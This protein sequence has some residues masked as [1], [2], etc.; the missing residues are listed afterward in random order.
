MTVRRSPN[1]LLAVFGI[2]LVVC[3]VAV[4][5]GHVRYSAAEKI[6]ESHLQ[7]VVLSP[8]ADISRQLEGYAQATDKWF[9]VRT[10][11]SALAAMASVG[12]VIQ[13][14]RRREQRLTGH[15]ETEA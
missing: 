5:Y 1:F 13:I 3:L 11:A 8:H 15:V 9:R 6:Y 7:H 10:A 14:V 2:L 4:M 12:I